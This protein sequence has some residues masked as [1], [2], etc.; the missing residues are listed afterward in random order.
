MI[1]LWLNRFLRFDYGSGRN[2]SE[3]LVI[4]LVIYILFL[5]IWDNG[6]VFLGDLG[7]L[8]DEFLKERFEGLV[9]GNVDNRESNVSIK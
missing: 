4:Y 8:N 9:N 3:D 5:E 2:S 1:L 6:I 7:V